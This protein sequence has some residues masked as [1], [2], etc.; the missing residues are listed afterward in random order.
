MTVGEK[1]QIFRKRL[2]MSQEEL[3]QKLFVSRQT[4]SLWEKDQTVPTID[5]LKRLSN[6]FCVSV[7][8][9][10]DIE[11]HENNSEIEPSET[12]QFH[13]EK[14]ELK[15]IY[16]LQSRN[17]YIKT[18]CFICICIF[19]IVF[20]IIS[21]APDVMIGFA[22]GMLYIGTA[23]YIKGF[24]TY[25]KNWN[26][27]MERIRASTY[28]YKL[29]ENY[30]EV[31]IYRKNEQI[32]ASKCYYKDIEQIQQFGNWLFLCFGG[33]SFLVRRSDLKENSTFYSYMYNN[34][35]KTVES[36]VQNKWRIIQYLVCR[37]YFVHLGRIG[38]GQCV[39]KRK[40]TVRG[41]YVAVLFADTSSDCIYCF[42]IHTEIKRI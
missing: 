35:S 8:E 28:E 37:F 12:Y 31:N 16:R 1:I 29:F 26:N 21:S 13:Y 32:R 10:L 33:Q 34:P 2:G 3:G 19:L 42:W 36:A 27:S 25:Y 20:F 17:M 18:A 15:K 4:I 9:I 38:F 22:F 7:D 41:K 23:F 6:I 40:R 11:R 14:T 5:N 24:R 39:F 30:M